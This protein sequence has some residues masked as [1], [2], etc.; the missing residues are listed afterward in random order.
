MI[1]E[2][3]VKAVLRKKCRIIE[4]NI[5]PGVKLQSTS[6]AGKIVAISRSL[7]R[8]I[9]LEIAPTDDKCDSNNISM[10]NDDSDD[11]SIIKVDQIINNERMSDNAE[12]G[13]EDIS[14]LVIDR[15]TC[16]KR[17]AVVTGEIEQRFAV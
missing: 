4:G 13:L 12:L 11:I 1:I 16:P 17:K 15:E 6:P 8:V 7:Q 10:N 9:P 2:E 5:T 14:E 3:T